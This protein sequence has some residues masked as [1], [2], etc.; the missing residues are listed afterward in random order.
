MADSNDEEESNSDGPSSTDFN[1]L[2][3]MQLWCL[4]KERKDD[5][6]K[7][8]DNKSEELYQLRKKSP[9]DLWMDDLEI[10]LKELEVS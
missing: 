6:L 4:T 10:F 5:L 9:K 7:Q 1:Y 3:S 2:L 8:R